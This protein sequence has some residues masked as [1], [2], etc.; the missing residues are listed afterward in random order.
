MSSSHPEN[1]IT[2]EHRRTLDERF[3]LSLPAEFGEAVTDEQG[4]TI[5]VKERP[6]CLSLWKKAEWQHRLDQGVALLRQKI[7]AGRLEQRWGDVQRLG[8]LLST[9][10]KD[11]R[12]ANRSR[13]VLPEG[14]REFLTTPA[15]GDV[16]VVG[17]VVCVEIW[18]PSDWHEFL[19]AESTAFGSLF[20]ELTA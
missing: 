1:F 13:L 18:N 10:A 3:R 2:G 14:F 11:V 6:G 8:R 7:A 17:A 4:E 15:E 16:V 5:L 12:L 9:R 19:R 20:Q